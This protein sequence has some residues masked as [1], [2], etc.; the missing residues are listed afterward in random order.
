M[1][2]TF[3]VTAGEVDYCVMMDR[4]WDTYAGKYKGWAA[5]EDHHRLCVPAD[6]RRRVFARGLAAAGGMMTLDA[7]ALEP[8]GDISLF[9][10]TWASQGRGYD[11][12]LH[13]GF[14][15]MQD[16]EHYHAETAEMALRGLRRKAGR[17]RT[18]IESY[19][20]TVE[21]F[22]ARY[23]D[24]A[25]AVTLQDARSTGS[26]EY[27]IRSWCERVGLD[28]ELN[29][30]PLEAV[31]NAFCRFPQVEVRRAVIHAVRRIRQDQKAN[32]PSVA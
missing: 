2:V 8:A 11:V 23:A 21:E 24:I 4:N 27:G 5:N 22:S 15:A 25:G 18:Y 28:Y 16:D 32:P 3:A 10:A 1:T 13:H 30:A 26:C 31:L 29:E 17:R 9:A 12:Q 19:E 6:W 20:S 7:H 14:I